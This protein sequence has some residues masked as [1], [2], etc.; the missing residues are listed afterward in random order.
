MIKIENT[1]FTYDESEAVGLHDI[2]LKI[3]KGQCIVLTGTSGCGKTTLTRLINGLIPY[4]YSGTLRGNVSID[5]RE[6]KKWSMEALSTKV[7]SVFQNPRSQ[8]FNLDT[9]SEI[10]FGCENLGLSRE[11]IHRRVQKTVDDLG[12]SH[13]MDRSIF[14]L[15]G[16]EKQMVAIASTYAMGPDIFVMDEPSSNLDTDATKELAQLI[17]RL[18]AK[19][20]TLI[21][22]EHRL[23][24][25][26]GIADRILYLR[27]GRLKDDWT[28]QEFSELTMKERISRGLRPYD[29]KNIH[30]GDNSCR[31]GDESDFIVED[32]WASYHKAKAVLC[33]ITC[34]AA[35]GEIIAIIGRNGGGKTS[36]A[37]CLCGLLKENKGQVQYRGNRLPYKK[38]IGKI[39]L[40]MQDSSCQLFSD[41]VMG[42]LALSC[43]T[44]RDSTNGFESILNK[45]SLNG[46]KQR[47]P[48]SLS[49]GEKQRLAIAAGIVQN[50]DTMIL[51][52]P[53]SG[54]DYEN[55]QRVK[56]VME[57]L[58]NEGKRIFIIT[59]D[60]EFLVSTCDRV[61]EI[62][63]GKIHKEYPVDLEHLPN[64]EQFFLKSI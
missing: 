8:F 51:D 19:G 48:M 5:G 40:V 3:D 17:S 23:Y 42:E 56:V 20:K 64:L 1:S 41:S 38:R 18:K 11:E 58:R 37:R 34:K 16:G 12:I 6:L 39:Y 9:T 28:G 54:L 57:T 53:T 52:E 43:R 63:N 46:L 15:S 27:D 61:I 49:G 55:M 29:L 10:A 7:G 59:H 2:S 13:L 21:I 33:G 44:N 4:F 31:K 30:P 32:L 36:F 60:Y 24:Y 26:K 22:A 35:P 14:S 45:L 25:L 50:S 62:E 47:H